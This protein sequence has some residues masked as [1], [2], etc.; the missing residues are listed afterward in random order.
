MKGGNEMLEIFKKIMKK[1][2]L[3]LSAENTPFNVV[4]FQFLPA[5]EMWNFYLSAANS[6]PFYVSL[7]HVEEVKSLDL[8]AHLYTKNQDLLDFLNVFLENLISNLNEERSL[9]LHF[10]T[11]DYKINVRLVEQE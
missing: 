8:L 5:L 2:F 1:E 7:V 10:V 3:Q 6:K 11:S 9:R 4:E